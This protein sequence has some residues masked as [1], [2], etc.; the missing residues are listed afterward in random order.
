M[1]YASSVAAAAEAALLTGDAAAA[2]VRAAQ[3][4]TLMRQRVP[5]HD[6][7]IAAILPAAR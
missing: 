5:E 7:R 4:R 6:P 2:Q 1:S 3:A